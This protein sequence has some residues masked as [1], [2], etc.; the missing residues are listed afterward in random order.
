MAKE[1]LNQNRMIVTLDLEDEQ[2]GQIF[3][4]ADHD[5][6]EPE[7]IVKEAV[8][9]YLSQLSSERVI[10]DIDNLCEALK[11]YNEAGWDS[12]E[13]RKHIDQNKFR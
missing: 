2:Y 4:K 5:D 1:K 11:I 12:V 3:A 6:C 7:D 9:V 10:L 8:E 13:L